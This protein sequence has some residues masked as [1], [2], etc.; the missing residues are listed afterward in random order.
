[1]VRVTPG[2]LESCPTLAK[3]VADVL[4]ESA[5]RIDRDGFT[6]NEFWNARTGKYCTRGTITQVVFDR[7]LGLK[8]NQFVWGPVIEACDLVLALRL[9][10]SVSRWND[11]PGRTKDEIVTE[12]TTAAAQVRSELLELSA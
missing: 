9:G 12:L 1:M 11:E 4:D 3:A 2:L 10:R 5:K 6:Q 7:Y 8:G